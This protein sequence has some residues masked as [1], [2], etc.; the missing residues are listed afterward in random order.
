MKKA[1]ILISF[2]FAQLFTSA[3]TNIQRPKLKRVTTSP[4]ATSNFPAAFTGN[5]K[6]QLQWM[7]NGKPTQTFTMQ[8]RIQPTDSANQYTWQIIYG[9]DVKDNRPYILKPVDTAKGHWIIDEN[10]GIILDSYVHGNS[11]HGAFTV[12]GNTIVDNYKVEDGKMQVE[13]FSIKLADKNQSG[14]GTAETP[15]V[16]SYKISSYQTGVLARVK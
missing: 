2:C 9:D 15:F 7:V 3:Q 6:G 11:I 16:D 5:W 13:F 14:K 12:Q 1:V 10:D 8:L 4:I